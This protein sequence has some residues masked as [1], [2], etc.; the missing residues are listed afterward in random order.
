VT[1]LK[2]LHV[3]YAID[4]HDVIITWAAST[5][6]QWALNT[7]LSRAQHKLDL[8]LVTAPVQRTTTR[9]LAGHIEPNEKIVR[10]LLKEGAP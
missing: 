7:V 1:T 6:K 10:E 5:D 9:E 2:P 8:G 4:K 3:A